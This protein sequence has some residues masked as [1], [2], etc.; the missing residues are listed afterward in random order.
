MERENELD[1]DRATRVKLRDSQVPSPSV[2]AK[3]V[4]DILNHHK[5][6]PTLW[7]LICF[8]IETLSLGLIDYPFL[9][10][11]VKKLN[12]LIYS[13]HYD[14]ESVIESSLDLNGEWKKNDDRKA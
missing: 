13:I 12:V 3:A 10:P 6:R 1:I 2:R 5:P 4:W 11:L 7:D 14:H 9:L 8:S